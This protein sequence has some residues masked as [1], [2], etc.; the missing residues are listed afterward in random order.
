[1]YRYAIKRIIRGREQFLPLFLS[2]VLATTLFAGIL[3]G[4]DA[5][6]ASSLQHIYDSAPYDIISTAPDK[7]ITVT[8]IFD[9]E[10][11]FGSIDGVT[12]VDRF[13]QWTFNVD[14]Q[15][16]NQTINEIYVIAV[17]DGSSLFEGVSEVTN[18]E[19]GKIY[20]DVESTHVDDL[21]ESGN[22][23]LRVTTYDPTGFTDFET[24][25]FYYPVQGSVSISDETWALFV[26]RY[27]IYLQNIM[28]RGEDTS[29]RPN[30]DLVLMSESTLMDII[31]SIFDEGRR[32]TYDQVGTV[33]LSLDRRTLINPWDIRTSK[34]RID[35]IL[36]DFNVIGAPYLYTANNFIGGLLTGIL[37]FTN[38]QKLSTLLVSLPVFFTAWFLGITIAEVVMDLR[39]REIGMLFTRGLNHRQ[40]LF[41]LLFEAL[42]ISILAAVLGLVFSAVILPFLFKDVN[43]FDLLLTTTPLTMASSLAFSTAISMLS[44]YRPAQKA[45][46]INI[47]DALREYD[48]TEE[49]KTSYAEPLVALFLGSYRFIMLSVGYTVDMFQPQ[50]TNIILT[51]LYTTWW[52]TDYL[53]SFLAPIL[54]FWGFT[55][56]F[57]QNLPWY[58][59]I[60][61]KVSTLIAG[62]IAKFSALSSRR[63][64]KRTAASTFMTALIV[65]YS[66]TVIGNI[67]TS[68]DFMVSAVRNSVGADSSVWLFEG[69]NA[70]DLMARIMEI[71]GVVS[72]TL[73]NHFTSDSSISYIPIRAIDPLQWRETAY[74]DPGWIEDT[75]VFDVMDNVENHAILDRGAADLLKLDVNG[76]ILINVSNKY[77]PIKIVGFFGKI[78]ETYVLKNPTLYL[79]DDFL[80]NLAKRDIQQKRILVKLETDVD[81]ETFKQQVEALDKDVQKVEVTVLTM[82][83]ALNNIL[84]SGPKKVNI[85]G[86]YFAGLVASLGILLITSTM[87]RTRIKELTIMSIRGFSSG[88]MA[89]S[90]LVES[91]GM[92]LFAVVLGSIVGLASLAG[93][94]NILNQFV[95]F[96][97]EHRVVFPL[98]AQIQLGV[99]FGLLAISTIIPII[100]SVNRISRKPNLKLED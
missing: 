65:G 41:L 55:K 51:V 78:S 77:Y 22:V 4:A 82:K 50:T 11:L 86:A 8:R 66:V 38:Q 46:K 71:D 20:I 13:I 24:R 53:L 94:V 68:D 59:I 1:M 42:V 29:L 26:E 7:N 74:I 98:N 36:V 97:F 27:S 34:N 37:N 47:V 99:I 90:L 32:P 92:D 44:V 21:I 39:K 6:G 89:T 58:Q 25:F 9:A 48:S 16:G 75:S 76:S 61:E 91:L 40:V 10:E 62:D 15:P 88:Q 60:L 84:V 85:L 72:A 23:T 2:V 54:F 49:Y 31:Q 43:F 96:N 64:I 30:Y 83:T 35:Q 100:I 28:S 93:I 52:G 80:S 79:N 56:L 14:Y 5:I 63:N 17:P 57:V 45:L 18:F 69:K 33:L 95:G 67:A 87:I 81:P 12:S 19:R 73:E 3:N 70:E